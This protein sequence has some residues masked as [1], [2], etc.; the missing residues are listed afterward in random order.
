MQTLVRNLIPKLV[1][2]KIHPANDPFF[3]SNQSQSHQKNDSKYTNPT[4]D[5]HKSCSVTPPYEWVTNYGMTT[6][7]RTVAFPGNSSKRD[8][9]WLRCHKTGRIFLCDADKTRVYS[10]SLPGLAATVNSQ[11]TVEKSLLSWGLN[12]MN[13]LCLSTLFETCYTRRT[14]NYGYYCCYYYIFSLFWNCEFALP[15][16]ATVHSIQFMI[17]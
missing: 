4:S 11:V 3:I 2:I 6:N 10:F 13:R 5:Q 7:S 15:P 17:V 16:S 12:Y 8:A 1:H 9:I 14:Y